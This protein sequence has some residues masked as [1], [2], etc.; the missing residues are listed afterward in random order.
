MKNFLT[1]E[2]TEAT[3]FGY[4][5]FL[6]YRETPRRPEEVRGFDINIFSSSV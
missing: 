6:F 1:T 5:N 3:E 4:E 2:D